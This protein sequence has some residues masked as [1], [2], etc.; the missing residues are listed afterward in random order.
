MLQI[1]KEG[2]RCSWS[3]EETKELLAIMKE[4]KLMEQL[5]GKTRRN[6]NIYVLISNELAKKGKFSVG[7]DT[8]AVETTTQSEDPLL[9]EMEEE[10]LDEC[11]VMDSDAKMTEKVPKKKK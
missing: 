9:L 4:K 6:N 11:D 5:D 7:I 3:M 8:T 2:S 1:K 10:H